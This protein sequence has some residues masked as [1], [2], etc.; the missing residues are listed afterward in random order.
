MDATREIYWNVGHGVILP[1]Y[2]LT[3]ATLA[4]L[5]WGIWRRLPHYRQGRPLQRLDQLGRRCGL[6]LRNLLTQR[7]VRRGALAGIFH[8]FFFWGFA[9]LFIGTLLIMLQADLVQP[10]FSTIFLQGNFYRGY[11]LVLDLAGLL[12]LLMLGA[13]LV[14]RFL[15]RPPGLETRRD[16][17]LM[18]GLLFA[19]LLTGFAIEGARLA[20]TELPFNPELALWSPVGRVVALASSVSRERN[21]QLCISGCGGCISSSLWR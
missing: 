5:F 2:L 10:L 20:A 9:L 11:S 14:R 21:W 1:M 7:S 3:F 6:L 13:L 17:Y 18:H 16:D 8:S 12:A 15:L 19:I 4:L